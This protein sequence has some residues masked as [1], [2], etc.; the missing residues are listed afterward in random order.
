VSVPTPGGAAVPSAPFAP[1][2]PGCVD[3]APLQ[4]FPNARPPLLTGL[5]TG[6]ALV[7][8]CPSPLVELPPAPPVD[9]VP[10]E[11]SQVVGAAAPP[12]PELPEAA[13]GEA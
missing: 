1:P 2:A 8:G 3:G 7:P 6:G 11:Q 10:S 12:C 13:L 4:P 9:D 5:A